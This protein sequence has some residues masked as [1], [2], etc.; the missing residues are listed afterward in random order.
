MIFRQ[1][2]FKYNILLLYRN[3]LLKYNVQ[4][5]AFNKNITNLEM[6]D[7]FISGFGNADLYLDNNKVKCNLCTAVNPFS[8]N[9]MLQYNFF[10]D[11]FFSF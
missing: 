7:S 6:C 4:A 5:E 10:N 9:L 1:N 2:T 3:E 8:L 11:I